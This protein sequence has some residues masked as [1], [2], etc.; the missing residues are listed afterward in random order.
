MQDA[1]IRTLSLP[2][3]KTVKPAEPGEDKST[4]F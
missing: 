3:K 4:P 1:S 2:D